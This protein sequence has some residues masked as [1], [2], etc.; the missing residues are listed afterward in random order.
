MLEAAPWR[1]PGLRTSP[2]SA[3]RSMIAPAPPPPGR[4]ALVVGINAYS[5]SPLHCCL[6]DATAV[7]EALQRMGFASMLV[8]DCDIKTFDRAKGVFVNSLQPGDIAF[9][10]FAGHGTEASILQAGRYNA[11]NWLIALEMPEHRDDLPRFA[12]DAHNLLAEIGSEDV[13][14]RARARLLP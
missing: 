6:N 10:Y 3:A 9:F 12:V 5:S 11:S 2:V 4:K 1:P 8:T 14:Q 7:H 13:V